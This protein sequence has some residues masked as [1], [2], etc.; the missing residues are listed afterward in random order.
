MKRKTK[1][2][3]DRP[4]G[5]ITV[6]DDFLPS[7]RELA[8]S[9]ATKKVT[10]DIETNIIEFF[11]QSAEKS[12]GKYQRLIREVLKEYAKHYAKAS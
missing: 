4:Y 9:F 10:I 1:I 2:D 7:P 3:P 6:V 11:K 5:K 8:K 12:G